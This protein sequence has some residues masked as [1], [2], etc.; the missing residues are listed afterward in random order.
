M[1]NHKT[2]PPSGPLSYLHGSELKT[3]TSYWKREGFAGMDMWNAPT[4]QSRQPLTYKLMESMGLG[5]PRWLGSSWQRGIAES[6]SS[7]L[8]TLM[9]ETPGDLVWD[10]P[11]MQQASC[12]EGGPPLYLHVNKK[13]DDD[14]LIQEGQLSVTGESIVSYWWKYLY[15]VLVNI[16]RGLILRRKNMVRLTDCPDMTLAV[17]HGC[18]TTTHQHQQNLWKMQI[19]SHK[20]CRP[21]SDCSFR[22][23]LIWFYNVCADRVVSIIWIFILKCCILLVA[24]SVEFNCLFLLLQGKVN[25]EIRF[26]E[27]LNTNPETTVSHRLAVR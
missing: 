10:L 6:G 17:Y 9:I 11:C 4:V 8:S 22:S 20:H 19:E 2:L 27:Y 3:W 21:R 23:C 14:E 16:L 24:G 7:Q 25:L 13:S 18:K 15:K 12:L 1:L 5:G 26:D